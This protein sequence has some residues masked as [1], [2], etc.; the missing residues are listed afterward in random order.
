MEPILDKITNTYIFED[1]KISVKLKQHNINET[2]SNNHDKT[3]RKEV[4]KEI[5]MILEKTDKPK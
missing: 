5:T 4:E 3:F 2:L 1:L